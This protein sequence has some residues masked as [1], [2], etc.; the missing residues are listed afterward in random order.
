MN[1]YVDEDVMWQ[2]LKDRQREAENLRLIRS[3]NGTSAAQLAKT[4]LAG[5]DLTWIVKRGVH[6]RWWARTR[7]RGV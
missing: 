1:P 3:E 2:R 4:I 6:P 7:P 5:L